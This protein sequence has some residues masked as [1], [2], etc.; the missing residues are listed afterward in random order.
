M[1]KVFTFLAAIFWGGILFGQSTGLKLGVKINP[2]VS[3]VKQTNIDGEE[4]QDRLTSSRIGWVYGITA[5][6]LAGSNYGIHSGVHIVSKGYEERFTR[7]TVAI[8][9]QVVKVSSIELPLAILMRS[10]EVGDGFY[11]KGIFGLSADLNVGYQNNYKGSNPFTGEEKDGTIRGADKVKNLGLSFIL[12]PSIDWEAGIGILSLG[13][14]L[15]QGLTNINRKRNTNN[16]NTLKINYL[17]INVEYF[18]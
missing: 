6:L 15:H 12:G 7:D 9:D 16:E 5:N 13:L 14:S 4:V 10:N 18:F 17:S 8:S 3:Y 1:K 2:I 11:L